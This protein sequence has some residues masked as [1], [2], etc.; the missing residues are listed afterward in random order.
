MT[1]F[2]LKISQQLYTKLPIYVDGM[3]QRGGGGE[4]AEKDVS[5][6][7][8]HSIQSA[9]RIWCEHDTT[10]ASD[11]LWVHFKDIESMMNFQLKYL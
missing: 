6:R 5:F 8:E 2:Y 1:E 9:I 10:Q 3:F 11:W 7:N 4:A